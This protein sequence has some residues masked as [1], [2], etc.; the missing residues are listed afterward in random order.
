[1]AVARM[2]FRIFITFFIVASWCS[3]SFAS[4]S[5]VSSVSAVEAEQGSQQ[6]QRLTLLAQRFKAL[7]RAH[8]GHTKRSSFTALPRRRAEAA[9]QRKVAGVAAVA[10]ASSIAAKP[11]AALAA[12]QNSVGSVVGGIDGT[13]HRRPIITGCL[14]ECGYKEQT[15]VTQCQVCI[16]QNECRILGKC[17]PCLREAHNA[18]VRAKKI[19]KGILDDGGVSMMRDGMMAEMTAAKLLALE[20][21]RKLVKTRQGVLKAQREAEWAAEERHHAALHLIEE[22]QVLKGARLEVTRWKLQNEK[23]LKA[24][25]TRAREHR[26]ERQKAER[27]LAAAKKKHSKAERRL[28]KA[29]DTQ[30]RKEDE[31]RHAR[32]VLERQQ[33]VEDAER[34]VEKT[35][36]DGEWL[37]RGLRRRVKS[38]QSGARKA[39]EEL[40]VARAHERVARQRLDEA[41]VH[42]QTSVQSSQQADKA[43]EDSEQRLRKA[44]IQKVYS[45]YPEKENASAKING[46]RREKSLRSAAK[47]VV[48][49]SWLLQLGLLMMGFALGI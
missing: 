33:A 24:M 3:S 26:L 10:V 44:P 30:A 39:R 47:E 25:R 29:A 46:T 1:M 36:A 21:K 15:C 11:L 37:D 12:K 42:Y 2:R 28:E 23:K 40:L 31:E 45:P 8:I 19:D 43:A 6:Q 35:S 16:E 7:R 32:E 18:R 20:S 27:K 22:R 17:D 48:G 4:A 38:A 49:A 5:V 41:K 34:D 9:S 13:A 14:K